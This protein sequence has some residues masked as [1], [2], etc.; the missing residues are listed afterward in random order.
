M[1][2]LF[3]VF[4]LLVVPGLR[5]AEVPE[6]GPRTFVLAGEREDFRQYCLSGS[7]RTFY[8]QLKKEFDEN[9][10]TAE[11]PP[12]PQEYGDPDPKKRKGDMVVKWRAAQTSCNQLAGVAEAAAVLW[13]V[14]GEPVYLAK[15]KEF[16]LA[17]CRWSN[18]GATRIA[19]NDEAHFRLWRKLPFVYDQIREELTPVEKQEVLDA[20]RRRGRDSFALIRK[21]TADVQRNSIEEDAA[22]HAV[23]FMAMTG[24]AGLALYD[25]L[26]EAREWK[27]YAD[28]FYRNQFPPWGGDDGGWGEGNAY[29]RGNLEHARYQDALCAI[30]SPDAYANPFWRQT[31]YFPVY[32]VQPYK[33]TSFG[34]TPNAGKFNLEP[35]VAAT[36]ERLSRRFRDGYLR[37]YA[38]LENTDER[39]LESQG[40]FF[41]DER[42]PSGFE[43]LLRDFAT[44]KEP[45]PAAKP[46]ADLPAARWFR[47]VGWVGMHSALGQPAED[48][49]LS[50]KSSP[51]GSYSHS[52][53]DQNSFILNA[54]GEN[55]LI[56]SGYRE[57]HRSPHHKAFT[58]QTLSKNGILIGGQGQKPQDK[59]ARGK[60]LGMETTDRMVW[61]AGDAAEAYN[62]LQEKPVVIEAR[63]DVLMIDRRY[64]VLRDRVTLAE[65]Q[66][67]SL[68]LHAES[69][70]TWNAATRSATVQQPKAGCQVALAGPGE[71]WTAEVTSEF[72]TPVDE[73]Y[74]ATCPEQSH[75]T[76]TSPAAATEHVIY[77]VVWPW[78]GGSPQSVSAEL[79]DQGVLAVRRPDGKTD[80]IDF[81]SS[82]PKLQ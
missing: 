9:F 66:T 27:A 4:L 72:P 70:F 60:I 47:D 55:L 10:L 12:E 23:R 54:W 62:T 29:W 8:A 30:G 52:H 80:R 34:D 71:A 39:S 13:M 21:K 43:Y 26:P 5:A 51:Y 50:F 78:P 31:G 17:G 76:V 82:L 15:A 61:T 18:D 65:P 79:D 40:L 20:F 59:A 33:H 1:K 64:F 77:A 22:S 16:L 44:R 6:R 58:Q 81:S 57:Y 42:Y 49:M 2:S 41:S 46:L 11:P 37:S 69:P 56:N 7:G 38:D 19:Y 25:D 48:I 68:L 53:A 32:F 75:L 35:I 24:L 73:K 28:G 74:R 36:V 14:S 3:A 45:L 63:R 67:V